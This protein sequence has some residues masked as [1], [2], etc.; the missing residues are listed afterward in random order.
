MNT[1]ADWGRQESFFWPRRGPM[2]TLA[3]LLITTAVTGILL[4][5]QYL[6][7]LTPLQRFYLPSYIRTQ[8]IGTFRKT[9]SYRLLYVEDARKQFRLA[10]DRDVLPLPNVDAKSVPAPFVLSPSATAKDTRR[11]VYDFPKTFQNQPFYDYLRHWIYSDRGILQL[12]RLPLL[13]G[14]C[15]LA[16]Q[17]AFAIPRDV[18]RRQELRYGRRLRGPE[19]VSAKE[20]TLRNHADGI[21]F[22]LNTPWYWRWL[23]SA[24][25]GEAPSVGIPRALES[26]HFL[27]IG[28]TGSGKSSLLRQMLLQIRERGDAAILYD[29][30]TEFIKEFYSADRGDVILN[31]LDQRMPYWNPA[32]ELEH[33]AEADAIA[34]ALFPA[35][36]LGEDKA[37]FIEG[38][39]KIFAF[40]LSF[41]PKP[42]EFGNWL[43]R[44]E[45]ID[46]RVK[47][48]E[49]FQTI[50]PNAPAQRSGILGSLSFV[51]DSLR[52][53]PRLEETKRSWTALEWAKQ[54]QGWI[55]IT[56]APSFRK[57]LRP[58]I[59]L[60]L[61]LLVLRTM[62]SGAPG[63]VPV[64]FIL[65]ELAS[66]HPLPQLHTAI[67]ENRKSGNPVVMGFQGR[68]QL[69]ALYGHRAEAMLS[70]PAT[71]I[72]MK[73]AEAHSA[74]W[75]S[76]TIGSIEVERLR[77]THT[78]GERRTR[79]L[80]LDRHVEPLVMDSEISGLKDLR[81]Y[82][83][84]G[85]LVTRLDVPYMELPK[86]EVGLMPR[87]LPEPVLPEIE[88]KP[89]KKETTTYSKKKPV[90]KAA[91]QLEFDTT[92]KKQKIGLGLR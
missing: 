10:L 7:G 43:C 81:G 21:R 31:P 4:Q 58:L 5:F 63:K 76:E 62:N 71:K 24:F 75:V 68:S 33:L 50:N 64:W 29:P 2:S 19:M 51:G 74:K 28:D 30:A 39:R 40:L 48:T 20:F 92:P 59:S 1:D 47:G 44:E 72:F 80:M 90:V 26:H 89:Q 3:A 56:S 9:A 36:D 14:L 77:E 87:P 37:F 66:L 45:E 16:V 22:L 53:L 91:E 83:K 25:R 70:Q 46:R 49:Y 41:R 32:D 42:E 60:W 82:L 18:H 88:T 67:T 13:G 17:L 84:L 85:N 78:H 61:D 8:V 55:F 35:N 12:F 69:E 54:R 79:S 6:S 57:K 27:V 38:T 65:D 86:R 52:M 15:L 11:L 23:P 73:T 34:E